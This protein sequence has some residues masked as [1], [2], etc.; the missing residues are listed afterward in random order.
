[1]S[2]KEIND[3]DLKLKICYKVRISKHKNNL[4]KS[5]N[6]VF[7]IEKVKNDVPWRYVINDPNAKK[8][9][10]KYF[11]KKQLQKTNEKEFRIEKVINIKGNN[12]MLNRKD[13]IIH[14]IVG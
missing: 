3:K 10:L 9:F 1:M 5:Y 13:T 12:F 4:A 7:L 8:K 14:L 2:T 11:I 6:S